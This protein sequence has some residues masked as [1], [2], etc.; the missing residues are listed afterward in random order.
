[1]KG[2]RILGIIL[3]LGALGLSISF[4]LKSGHDEHATAPEVLNPL[5]TTSSHDSTSNESTS[6]PSAASGPGLVANE[7]EE[8]RQDFSNLRQEVFQSMPTKEQLA[9]LSGEEVHF[10]PQ[11]M[12]KAAVELGKIAQ[13]V[14]D[15]PGLAPEALEFYKQ[16]AEKEISPNS[17][18]ASCYAEFEKLSESSGLNQSKPNV[19][20]S[21]RDL[22]A[23]VM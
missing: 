15:H 22:A 16:C 8:V 12:L 9:K 17:L 2:L 3:V 14:A 20:E 21:I 19:P 6:A 13:A 4:W 11:V 23:Q 18:R 5:V 1:M 10:T 7:G